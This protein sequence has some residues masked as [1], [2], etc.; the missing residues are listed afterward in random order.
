MDS[1]H[2]P[3]LGGSPRHVQIHP[4]QCRARIC[5][6]QRPSILCHSL[7]AHRFQYCQ[8]CCTL[9]LMNF[10]QQSNFSNTNQST[11]KIKWQRIHLVT[12]LQWAPTFYRPQGKV[13]FSQASVCPQSASWLLGHCSSFLQRG[14]YA[15]YWSAFW[16]QWVPYFSSLTS[17]LFHPWDA[18]LKIPWNE[19][20]NQNLFNYIVRNYR[21][22]SIWKGNLSVRNYLNF[23]L[24]ANNCHS[25]H[26]LLTRSWVSNRLA[27]E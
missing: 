2:N 24:T 18:K 17:V 7:H 14:R 11:K 16:L 10:L 9:A 25:L 20:K 6:N 4:A 12:V 3:S 19:D 13:M 27:S 15:S 26:V 5:R 1:D 21:L 23:S 8:F 22:K